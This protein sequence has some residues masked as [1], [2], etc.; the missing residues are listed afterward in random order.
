MPLKIGNILKVVNGGKWIKV[1]AVAGE[2]FLKLR[3]MLPGEQYEFSRLKK[4]LDSEAEK[5]KLMYKMLASHISDWK[6]LLESDGTEIPYKA[7]LFKDETFMNSL[8][9]LT[10]N[11]GRFLITWI[12]QTINRSDAFA[13]EDEPD[14]L[15][16]I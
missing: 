9:A 10:V 2:F 13:Q 1:P 8:L 12:V 16:S 14:F 3:Q 4:S 11:D 15:A 7:E 6:G 5:D